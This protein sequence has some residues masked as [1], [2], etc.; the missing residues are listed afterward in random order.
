[1]SIADE[2]NTQIEQ[3]AAQT[4]AVILKTLQH[5]RDA[6]TLPGDAN[7]NQKI[8]KEDL[9]VLE[10]LLSQNE[11]AEAL[12]LQMDPRTLALFDINQ[13]GKIDVLDLIELYKTALLD[14]EQLALTDELTGLHNRRALKDMLKTRIYAA[15]RYKHPLCG[16]AIDIDYF[17]QINDRYG[18]DIGDLT[19]QHLATL[20]RQHSRIS[21]IV[22]RTG[23]EE[24][25]LILDH[26]PTAGAQ[27]FAEKLRKRVEDSPLITPAH[28]ISLTIS[29]GIATLH[30]DS[31]MDSLL[32]SADMALYTAKNEGRNRVVLAETTP[33]HRR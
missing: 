18:H 15:Q 3:L 12:L 29:A 19:L 26:T 2:K 1:M 8:D 9:E 11:L 4:Q 7:L 24:F 25:M 30:P 21:E 16:V 28:T 5:Q 27:T 22:A 13:D 33:I 20:M 10:L 31:D 17:K 6:G 32:K 23:G 14:M